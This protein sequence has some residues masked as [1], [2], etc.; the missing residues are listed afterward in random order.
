MKQKQKKLFVVLGMHRSGTSLITSCLQLLGV[1]LGD[2]LLPSHKDN[3][4]GYFEDADVNAL[5]IEI[6]SFLGGDWDT[7]SPI[8]ETKMGSLDKAGFVKKAVQLLKSK[9]ILVDSFAIKDPRMAKLL[10]FWKNVFTLCGLQVN[11]IVAIRN[12]MSVV[13]S[14]ASRD[15]FEAGKSYLLWLDNIV[16]SLA[17]TS[18]E[19]RIF[20]DYD[21]L[22]SHFDEELGALSSYFQLSIDKIKAEKF[23]ALNLKANLRHSLYS[24]GDLKKDSSC[25]QLVR[26]IYS[27]LY[28]C[29]N[30]TGEVGDSQLME[31]T[32]AWEEELQKT[33]VHRA[34]LDIFQCRNRQTTNKLAERGEQLTE[35]SM[36]L[37]DRENEL[38]ELNSC[39]VEQANL[40]VKRTEQI[41]E[42]GDQISQL[43]AEL[44]L[45]YA[46]NYWKITQPIR[47]FSGQA[48]RFFQLMTLLVPAIHK[49]G[50][51]VETFRKAYQLFRQD[52]LTGI[53]NGFRFVART[54]K[55]KDEPT[56]IL[57]NQEEYTY[58]LQE[59]SE[60]LEK[61]RSSYCEKIVSFERQPVIAI[62]VPT[63][64]SRLEWLI[65]CIESVQ[66]QIYSNWVLYLSDDG[67]QS[68]ELIKLLQEYALRDERIRVLFSDKNTGVS[69]TIN[70]A[71]ATCEEEFVVLLDHDDVIEPHALL[72]FAETIIKE[73]SDVIYSDEVLMSE[74]GV[75]VID[76][77][78]RPSFSLEYLRAHPYI[79]HLVGFKTSLLKQVGG[80]DEGLKVSQ[81]YD[82]ILKIVEQASSITHIP[83]LLYRWR[84]HASSLGHAYES[85]VTS[86]STAVLLK[87]LQRCNEP[88]TVT[89]DK[90]FNYFDVRYS[91]SEKSKVAII[92]PTKNHFDLVRQCID[93]IVSTVHNVDY[94]IIVIDHDSDDME[95]KKYF[96]FLRQSHTVLNYS[97]DFN[98]SKINNWAVKQLGEYNFTHYL[99]CNN[100]I[101]AI[102][103][104]WLERMLEL[105]EKADIGVVGTQLYYPEQQHIQHGGVTLGL[106]GL[107][108]HNGKFMA[109][110]HPDGSFAY[111]YRG[112]LIANH[113]L[114][115][116]TAACMLV[117]RDAFE[118]V[119]G[120]D[121]ML[122]VGFGDVDLCL[123]IHSLGYR[124]VLCPK[125]TLVHHESFT[126]GKSAGD[127]H[128]LDSALFSEKWSSLLSDGDPF[129]NP[130]LDLFSTNWT[131]RLPVG[132]VV[133]RQ[134]R[135][136]QIN[137][138]KGIV[139][140]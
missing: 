101:E 110:N 86:V 64:N 80:Y 118:R 14:L 113:E 78:F 29:A 33:G 40:V 116:T 2:S 35:R 140:G 54:Q 106:M 20:V 50:G 137:V 70:R 133:Y 96:S 18:G 45:L 21:R 111:G 26:R 7:F 55:Q 71:L 94:Q 25:P 109:V 112:A 84:Q 115:A 69:A 3:P 131:Y 83:E 126:R 58:W 135:T 15:D 132:E 59:H 98:F 100:D 57:C 91:V 108:E 38:I 121:E 124:I 120:Y 77:V 24:V 92:I 68:P 52:G 74:D 99:F 127:P 72:R 107:A 103:S 134:S 104:D 93:S 85:E 27:A 95:S 56:R 130:N 123:R 16:A 129:Y 67:S 79:V 76:F 19:H 128:P 81:D 139:E 37:V 8:S 49:G 87:H 51:L 47:A 66:Q 117:C 1:E 31:L 32:R 89:A 90:L 138:P 13:D 48:R 62:I 63:Y 88:G 4:A 114:L 43:E 22:M 119:D 41:A 17:Q 11:Y 97:G 60:L 36:Q 122:A 30:R 5:N 61:H 53:K 82:V 42:Q 10:F 44:V 46:S 39:L 65:T 28:Q 73:E 6:L 75:S 125:A 34:L 105:A 102:N 23:K 136:T 12:P 9:I